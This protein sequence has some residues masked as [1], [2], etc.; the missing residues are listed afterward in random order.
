MNIDKIRL[1]YFARNGR[2]K[3]SL[4]LVH[5]FADFWIILERHKN[6]AAV[7]HQ[8]LI[9]G[10][11]VKRLSDDI[12]EKHPNIPWKKIVGTR[13]ILIHCNEEAELTGRSF[14]F[15]KTKMMTQYRF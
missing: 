12:K 7:Q 5:L 13:D 6:V 3:S 2:S 8:I 15:T 4:S 14:A 9:L 10:E 1:K 11:A